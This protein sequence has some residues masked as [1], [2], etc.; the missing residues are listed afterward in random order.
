MR[1]GQVSNIAVGGM[2]NTRCQGLLWNVKYCKMG[3]P[4]VRARVSVYLIFCLCD[5]IPTHAGSR[6]MCRSRGN[7]RIAKAMCDTRR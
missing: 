4:R 1:H 7:N 6:C 3:K 2:F 5:L